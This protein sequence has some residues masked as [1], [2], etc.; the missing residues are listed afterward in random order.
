MGHTKLYVDMLVKEF[1]EIEVY[2][3]KKIK[4]KLV[5]SSDV[6]FFAS[7]LNNNKI[8]KLDKLL[9]YDKFFEGKD[10]FLL[11]TGIP[12]MDESKRS[13]VIEINGLDLYH[14]R[15]YLLPGGIDI[16]KLKPFERKLL[17]FALNV[18][19]KKEPS[20]QIEQ[21]KYLFDR[22]LNFVDEAN[23]DRIKAVYMN[24]AM[25]RNISK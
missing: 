22:P 6:V 15:L 23:L 4:K 3:G 24:I 14:V 1:K 7:F 18:A 13:D 5:K 21:V 20:A 12:P 2:P 19:A 10:V 11:V 17:K 16:S 9:K 25:E 8:Y